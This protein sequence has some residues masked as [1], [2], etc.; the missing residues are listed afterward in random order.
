MSDAE[1]ANEVLPQEFGGIGF[2]DLRQRFNFY[3]LSEIVNSH[4]SEIGASSALR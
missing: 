4:F 3:P 1:A 2:S